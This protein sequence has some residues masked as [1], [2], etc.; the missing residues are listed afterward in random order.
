MHAPA[1]ILANRAWLRC[2]HPF[3][4]VVAWNVFKRDFYEALTKQLGDILALG[5][6]RGARNRKIFTRHA[7]L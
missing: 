1:D 7:G 6:S 2:E 3:P 5:L 4:H